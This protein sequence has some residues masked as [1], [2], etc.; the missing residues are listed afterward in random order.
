MKKP[1]VSIV[2]AHPSYS[3]LRGR[4]SSSPTDS[5]HFVDPEMNEDR[6]LK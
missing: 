6:I 3:F 1:R 5:A 4:F 2:F